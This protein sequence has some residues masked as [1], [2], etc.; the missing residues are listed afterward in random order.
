MADEE[1]TQQLFLIR[2]AIASMTASEQAQ[3]KVVAAQLRGIIEADKAIGAIALA[4]IGAELSVQ[5]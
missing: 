2:G 1:Q 5:S 4:L 3:I